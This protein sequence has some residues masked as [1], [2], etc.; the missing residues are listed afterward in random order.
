MAR[1]IR[2]VA[3]IVAMALVASIMCIGI[4]AATQVSVNGSGTISMTA[5]DVAA[6]VKGTQQYNSEA[7]TDLGTVEFALNGTEIEG[8]LNLKDTITFTSVNDTATIKLT[9]KNGFADKESNNVKATLTLTIPEEADYTVTVDDTAY[10]NAVTKTTKGTTDA[11]FTIKISM[12]ETSQEADFSNTFAF[13]LDLEKAVEYNIG[14]KFGR[15]SVV[16]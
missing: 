16:P 7:V 4:Y 15:G 11:V 8:T 2:I 5:K 6:T 10:T 13:K 1:R 9:V 14:V 3:T 12:K